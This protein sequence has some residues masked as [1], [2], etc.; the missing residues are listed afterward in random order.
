[1]CDFSVDVRYIRLCVLLP[2]GPTRRSPPTSCVLSLA[3]EEKVGRY[4]E[5]V[6]ASCGGGG[7]G[8]VVPWKG[9]VKSLVSSRCCEIPRAVCW[10]L[11]A[12]VVLVLV[13]DDGDSDVLLALYY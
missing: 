13:A 2:L 9:L 12:V 6:R 8:V 3:S 1:M 7:D 4:R 10:S 11:V 5:L